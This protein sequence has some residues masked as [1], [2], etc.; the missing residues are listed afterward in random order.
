M[1][2]IA[3]CVAL[4]LAFGSSALAD[5]TNPATLALKETSP[6]RFTVELT[7]PVMQGR[8]PRARP[9]LPDI[10]VIEGEAEV[11]GDSRRV[12]RTWAMTCDPDDLVGTA[13]GVRG[14]LGTSLDVQLTLETLDGRTYV[15]QLRPTQAYYLVPP[16]PTMRSM[17]VEVGGAAARRVLRHPELAIL[18]LLCVFFGLRLPGLFASAGAFAAALALGQWLK[19]ENWIGVSSFLPVMLTAATGL[20]VA[21]SIIRGEASAPNTRWRTSAA[22]MALMGVLY[23]GGGLPVEMVLSRSEQHLAFL[24]SALGTMAGLA[25]VIL[26][27]GQLHAL[28]AGAGEGV[29]ERLRFW[30]AYLGGVAACAIGLYQGTAP[31]FVGGVTPTVPLAA[32][33]AAIALGAWCGAQSPP[34]R[35]FLPGVAGCMVIVGMVLSLRGISLPQTTLAVYGSLALVGLLLVWPVRW[36]GWAALVLVAVSSLYHGAHAGGVLRESVALPVAQATAMIVLL[37]FLFLVAYHRTGER[38]PGGAAVRL[39][40][41][42]TALLAVLWRFT[43]YRDWM[44]Q[45]VAFEATLGVFRL[46]VLTIILALAALL[47]W[48]RRRRFQPSVAQRAMPTHLC[49]VL[50][51]LF[52]VSAAGVRVRNPFYTPR[53]PTAAE[54]RPIMAALL[55][56][57]YLAFNL[58]DEDAAFDRLARNLSEDLVPGVY[59][60]S[61][62]RLMAG[63]RKG[64]EVTVKDVTVMSVDDPSTSDSGDGSFTYPCKWVV[65]ARVKHWQHIHDRQNIYVGILT[66]RVE[67]DRWK[68]AHL[69]LLSEE[70]EIVSWKSS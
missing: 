52:T 8:V 65:T 53:A 27:A 3:A 45:E 60:D 33:L 43:E 39:F 29:R 38:S 10:C 66:I 11:Q 1:K 12:V 36:P 14:L 19:A 22:F 63:T 70:R 7:L 6:S 21:L 13:I 32:L 62:R 35:S 30:V 68:I 59:L 41:L 48:P 61:R 23:G 20:A 9:V 2:R 46:P 15:G 51:A 4:L 57:T 28:V 44:G 17:L 58:P 49:L 26:C 56:D 69:E 25:L 34:V 54:A 40:G 42:A 47:A 64:A 55:T 5:L 37:V 16:P 24:F 31:F 18:L 67:D 50:V